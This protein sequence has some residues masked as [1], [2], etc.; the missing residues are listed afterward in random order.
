VQG[1]ASWGGEEE[2]EEEEFE[3]QWSS[4]YCL[5]TIQY[6]PSIHTLRASVPVER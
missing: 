4:W 5:C 6:H 1:R 3:F 2:E